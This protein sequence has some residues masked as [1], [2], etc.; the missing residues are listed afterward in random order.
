[1]IV[2][3]DAGHAGGTEFSRFLPLAT[4]E[5]ESQ[6]VGGLCVS[7][8]AKF[9]TGNLIAATAKSDFWANQALCRVAGKFGGKLGIGE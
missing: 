1:M 5:G 9:V 8:V 7:F 3:P 2:G 6:P 4:D